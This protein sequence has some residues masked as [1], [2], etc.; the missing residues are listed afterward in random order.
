MLLVAIAGGPEVPERAEAVQRFIAA[1]CP[2]GS[3]FRR[4]LRSLED[5]RD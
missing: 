4:Y 5:L 1:R 2:D 3:S